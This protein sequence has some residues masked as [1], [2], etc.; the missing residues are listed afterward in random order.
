MALLSMTRQ[1]YSDEDL[2]YHEAGHAVAAL[3]LGHSVVRVLAAAHLAH[4]CRKHS[5]IVRP[6]TFR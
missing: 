6:P 5:V 4:G 1:Q 3:L 2:A